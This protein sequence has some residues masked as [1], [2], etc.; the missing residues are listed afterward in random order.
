[1]ST[2]LLWPTATRPE[3]KD[4]LSYWKNAFHDA[5]DASYRSWMN[6]FINSSYKKIFKNIKGMDG[7]NK[8]TTDT[9]LVMNQMHITK[10]QATAIKF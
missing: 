10:L 9:I 6:V 8:L 2:N 5:I 1:M 4:K 3:E 7:Q